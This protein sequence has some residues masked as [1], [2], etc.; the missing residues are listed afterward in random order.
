MRTTAELSLRKPRPESEYREALTQILREL[1]TTSA[2]LEKL[3][4]LAR[5]D[6]GV[7][8][9]QFV[10]VDLTETLREACRQARVL[11]EGKQI[12]LS[13]QIPEGA[14]SVTGDVHALQRL[15][16]VLLDNAVKYTPPGGS[17]TAHLVHADSLVVAEI[18]DTGIGIGEGDLPHI[19]ERFYRA[20]KARSRELGGAGLGLS[21][22]RWITDTHR[23]AIEV[24]SVAGEG[25]VFL[26][27]LPISNT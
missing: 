1:E 14:I 7:E 12:T 23:G 10:P 20:D 25:S 11:A 24:Q 26:V 4:L 13:E 18:R 19:F 9:L 16:L 2:L 21:I 17:I 5:A 8:G 22:A 15:F 27:R 3:M 6:S